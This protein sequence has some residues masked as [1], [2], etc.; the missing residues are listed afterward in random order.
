MASWAEFTAQAPQLEA[1]VRGRFTAHRH[2]TMAT[3]RADGGPRISGTE[4]TFVARDRALVD[5]GTLPAGLY[6][7][8]MTGNRR[9]ADLRRDP[10]V[11]VHSGS[12]AP[13]AWRG[14]AKV[15]GRAV[16]VA[17]RAAI[18]AFRGSAAQSPAEDF[19]LFRIEPDTASAVRLADSGDHLVI[20]TWQAGGEITSVRR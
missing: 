1:A 16:E 14:D 3:L 12:D 8:G 15:S 9:F 20:D 10:R 18:D 4:V 13:D 17:G 5:G 11:A 7:G 2:L 19:E 6:L